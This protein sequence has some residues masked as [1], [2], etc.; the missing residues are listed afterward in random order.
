YFDSIAMLAF[1]LL[2]A[3]YAQ[4]IATRRATAALDG[5]LAWAA[6]SALAPGDRVAVAPGD[7]VPADGVVEQGVSSTDESLLTGESRPVPKRPGDALVAG[8]GDKQGERLL[9]IHRAGDE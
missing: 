7:R 6:P 1:L 2:G 4:L 8:S 9:E 3:R 5:L